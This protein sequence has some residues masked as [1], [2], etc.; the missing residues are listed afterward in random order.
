MKSHMNF[1]LRLVVDLDIA[2]AYGVVLALLSIPFGRPY[3]FTKTTDSSQIV[4][5]GQFLKQNGD[6]FM[7]SGLF[8]VA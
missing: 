7:E 3:F 8:K 2:G 6:L 1:F 5:L 4:T